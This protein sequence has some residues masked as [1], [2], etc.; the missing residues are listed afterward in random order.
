MSIAPQTFEHRT[1]LHNV[2]WETYQS[3]RAANPSGHLRM[4]YDNGELEIMSPSRK[5]ERIAVLLGRMIDQWTMHNHI[6]VGAGRNT[7]F[8]R[9]D[10]LKGLEPDNCYWITNELIM[11]DRDE[12]NLTIDPPPDLAIEV[13]ISRSS[14]S[15]VP[16][17]QSL[18]V[19]ELWR[20]RFDALE[21]LRLDESGQYQPQRGSS[22][23][24]GF[25]FPLA[26]QVVGDRHQH[27]DTELIRRF[28]SLL[29]ALP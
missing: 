18:G 23:L 8:T 28:V 20:W 22:E 16:I 13:D 25:P 14:I 15:K 2:P 1:L 27:D 21:V 11:R 12:V 6:P 17:Y 26:V 4:T 19:P 29:K 9:E 24:P 10:I 7:T 5:H 3:L